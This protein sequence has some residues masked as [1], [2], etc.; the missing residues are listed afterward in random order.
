MF[1]NFG[2]FRIL[3]NKYDEVLIFRTLEYSIFRHT[4]KTLAYSE[5]KIFK[6]LRIF[7]I[8]FTQ[9]EPWHIHDPFIFNLNHIE[10]PRNTQKPVKH[11]WRAVFYRTLCNTG[12]FRSRGISRTLSNIYDAKFYSQTCVTLLPNI[13]Q[14]IFY[15]KPCVTL[16]YSELLVFSEL[17]HVLKSKHIQTLPN[18]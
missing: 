5:I 7:K 6:I 15:S 9:T 2:F 10:S 17:W 18:I 13:Y 3:S 12:I 14:E 4:F 8:Q 16:K 1:W 11:V